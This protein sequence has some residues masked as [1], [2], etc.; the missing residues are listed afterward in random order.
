MATAVLV[1]LT[2]VG[3]ETVPQVVR[4]VGRPDLPKERVCCRDG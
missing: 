4:L 1:A 2:S 3:A